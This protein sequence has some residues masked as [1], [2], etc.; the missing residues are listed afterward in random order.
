MVLLT[1][2][3]DAANVPE[4]QNT[5]LPVATRVA[6]LVSLLTLEE[7]VANLDAERAPGAPRIGLG[8][9]RF[10]QECERGAVT[11]GVNK[12]PLGTGFPTPLALGGTF[13]LSLI[14]AVARVSATEVRAYYNMDRLANVTT[15]GNCYAPVVNVV[16]DPRW[17]RAQEMLCGE[18]PL[19]GR[20]FARVWT[21]AMQGGTNASAPYRIVTS[22]AK[23]LATYGGPESGPV[24][25]FAF[26]AVLD[27]RTWRTTFLPAFRGS[28]EAGVDGFMCRCARVVQEL[29]S[30]SKVLIGY[31]LCLAA[32]PQQLS[33][34]PPL[35]ATTR[36]TAPIAFSS[37]S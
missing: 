7:L 37:T 13:N 2:L 31:V 24:G 14:A 17:G 16:R 1:G 15:G 11:S 25:R 27:E 35:Q 22:V 36:P 26:D 4:W 30:P 10:D 21:A 5:S 6:N 34:T 23:H 20:L 19:L 32:T 9:Y 18:D 12:R 3:R 28:A 8:P 33:R 29:G